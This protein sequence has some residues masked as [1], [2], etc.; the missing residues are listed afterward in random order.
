MIIL[1]QTIHLSCTWFVLGTIGTIV[2][3]SG[4]VVSSCVLVCRR[5]WDDL[6]VGLLA[7]LGRFVC[8]RRWDDL[9]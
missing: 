7:S 6:C 1:G 4:D 9:C 3:A 5:R 2:G 8:W